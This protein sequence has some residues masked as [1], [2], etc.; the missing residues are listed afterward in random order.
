MT[1]RN[2]IH[3]F[4]GA[5]T[6]LTSARRSAYEGSTNKWLQR[7]FLYDAGS[8]AV[9]NCTT[10]SSQKDPD[11]SKATV[12]LGNSVARFPASKCEEEIITAPRECVV[13]S[14]DASVLEKRLSSKCDG[15]YNKSFGT[16]G[17]GKLGELGSG[18]LLH[19]EG[20]VKTEKEHVGKPTNVLCTGG[21]RT[22]EF[23]NRITQTR[24]N[25]TESRV[26]ISKTVQN[27]WLK[28]EETL[29][30]T[31][32]AGHQECCFR[33]ATMSPSFSTHSEFLGVLAASQ[34]AFL[35]QKCPES[36]LNRKMKWKTGATDTEMASRFIEPALSSIPTSGPREGPV[37][38]GQ[39]DS[40]PELFSDQQLSTH[41][42]LGG[43]LSEGS[44]LLFSPVIGQPI[45]EVK[46]EP[47]GGGILCSQV[48]NSAK[49]SLTDSMETSKGSE[50]F[51]KESQKSRSPDSFRK[52]PP[53]PKR[54]KAIDDQ[55]TL[56]LGH[57]LQAIRTWSPAAKLGFVETQLLKGCIDRNQK[58]HILVTMQFHCLLK[59]IEIKSG[60]LAG[61]RVPMSTIVVTDQSGVT[62]KVV[63]WR[64]AAFWALAIFPG[65][66]FLLTDVMVYWDHWQGEEVLQSSRRSK[67]VKLGHCLQI[68][69][70]QWSQ[71]V[72]P[73]ALK[74]LVA[75]ISHQ[76]S[77]LLSLG[78]TNRQH[79]ESVQYVDLYNLQ[80]GLVVHARLKI[81]LVTVLTENMYTYGGKK[82]QKIV[83]TVE[84][85]KD[86]PGTLTLWGKAISWRTQ[87]QTKLEHIWDFRILLVCQ[88][89]MSGDL[90]LH[91]TP[92]SSCECLF[93]DDE[94]AIEFRSKYQPSK[95]AFMKVMDLSTLLSTR[96]S[97]T[98]EL[99]A[100]IIAM[101]W[102][103]NSSLD[104]LFAMDAFTAVETVLASLPHFTYSGCGYCGCELRFDENGI[105]QQCIPCLPNS[106]LK[107]YYRPTVLTLADGSSIID[108]FVSSKLMEKIFLNIPPNW[109]C[110]PLGRFDKVTY[111]LVVADLSC[112]LFTYPG[113]C[114]ILTVQS[115]LQLDENSIPM[116]Q[117][118]NL[119]D[120]HPDL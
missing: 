84:Q 57:C 108:V 60:S 59:E 67:L 33:N 31:F 64:A 7:H 51:N 112:S 39:A 109:L 102:D 19:S 6:I 50:E 89:A 10:E 99:R 86:N 22:P 93:D 101:R 113:D 111:G 72:N 35:L 78:P 55:K 85:L 12:Q 53:S 114:Y 29:E 49:C 23:D 54:M 70:A 71:T 3:I 28:E 37:V 2:K 48:V 98:V 87:I 46:I 62:M 118:F 107:F 69:A 90:E 79:S 36:E 77:H 14:F 96:C 103:T 100:H 61:S 52:D 56:H 38:C 119:L 17:K 115:Q 42:A 58:Y 16:G 76:H 43:G 41:E 34:A 95:V 116:K 11:C 21:F 40:S 117:D 5:P 110:K 25:E 120:F 105:Y 30:D 24:E 106:A 92:W 75:Y 80:P 66:I 13:E 20:G 68:Q 74:E 27:R 47:Y 26:P 18:I 88:N 83:L 1:N 82:Q 45:G 65:D 15:L 73:I 97:A 8:P 32:P 81:V 4:L 63:L 44:E 104:P 91:T 94:R 9:K